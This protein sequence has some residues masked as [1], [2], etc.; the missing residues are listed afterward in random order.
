MLAAQSLLFMAAALS[1]AVLASPLA[2]GKPGIQARFSGYDCGG[3]FFTQAEAQEG[4]G[5]A[6]NAIRTDAV[7]FNGGKT[8]PGV[9]RNGGNNV[10]LDPSP[11]EGKQL[12]EFPI[13]TTGN[14]YTGGAPGAHRVVVAE[15][16]DGR[17]W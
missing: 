14:G 3:T 16:G 12:L 1:S 13:L 6:V 10:E 17:S 4:F 5:D 8:Y 15:H 9:F 2:A 11:C 7:Y